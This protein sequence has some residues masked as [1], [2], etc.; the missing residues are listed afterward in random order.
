[1]MGEGFLLKKGWVRKNIAIKP[2]SEVI[3]THFM[4]NPYP[5]EIFNIPSDVLSC[6]HLND[7]TCHIGVLYLEVFISDSQSL[8]DKR[9]H[10][11][12]MKDKIRQKFNVSVSEVGE[13]DKWQL[14]CLAFA[15]TGNDHKFIDASLQSIPD[16]IEANYPVE[17]SGQRLEFC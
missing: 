5:E 7:L 6:G 15:M 11:K 9:H 1:M 13:L 3:I 2:Y 8:K 4:D 17:I 14:A 16:Y 12:S 10:I